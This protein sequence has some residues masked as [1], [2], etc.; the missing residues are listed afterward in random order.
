MTDKSAQSLIS[1]DSSGKLKIY[2]NSCYLYVN[3]S[4]PYVRIT[5]GDQI[6]QTSISEYP[7]G[8]W[9]EGFELK[10]SYHAQLFDTI[11]LDVYDYYLL[12]PDRHVGRA[13]IRLIQLENMPDTFTSFFEVWD[14]SLASGASSFATRKTTATSSV[15]ALQAKITYQFQSITHYSLDGK[16]QNR[17]QLPNAVLDTDS[18]DSPPAPGDTSEHGSTKAGNFRQQIQQYRDARIIQFRKYDE[19]DYF[20]TIIEDKEQQQQEHSLYRFDDR[21]DCFG[22]TEIS[23]NKRSF[24]G[25]HSESIDNHPLTFSVGGIESNIISH[26][27]PHA[28][29]HLPATTKPIQ[30]SQPEEKKSMM[31]SVSSWFAFWN[32][33]HPILSEPT[34]MDGNGTASHKVDILNDM[35]DSLKPYPILDAFGSWVIS[36]ETNQVLRAIRKLLAAFGQGFELSNLQVL[37]GSAVVEKFYQE[38]TRERTY[39][40]VKDVSEM[41][42]ASHL[43]RFSMA[44]YGWKGLNFI[45]QGNGY[46]LDA[47]RFHSNARSLMEHLS[48]SEHD[49]LAYEFRSGQAFRPSYFIAHDR[50]TNSIVLSIR[51][52]MGSFDTMTDLVCEY[53]PWK[54]G[55]VHKGMKNSA[56]WFFDHLAPKLIAYINSQPISALYIVGHSLGAATAAILTIMLLDYMDELKKGK[57]DNFVLQ[58][59]GYA[60]ACGLSLELSEKYK[61]HIQSV[62]FADDVVSKLCYGSMM[63]L[64]QMIIAGYEATQRTGISA[65]V[66][67]DN[68][69]GKQKWEEVFKQVAECR[70]RCIESQENPRLYVAGTVYQFW[71]DPT[72]ENKTRIV[73]ERTSAKRVSSELILKKSIILDHLPSTFDI[74]MASVTP[75][76]ESIKTAVEQD[77]NEDVNKRN[78]EHESTADKAKTILAEHEL[79][80]TSSRSGGESQMI[81]EEY[82]R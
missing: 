42:L 71:L 49:L 33:L 76:T 81:D 38:L 78:Q 68:G 41:Q 9:N 10:V 26:I 12:L 30:P 35:D 34:T 45:G 17:G 74:A 73:V 27:E 3:I 25:H 14:K 20:G 37:I 8:K 16:L 69:P 47:T 62:V 70:Q 43:W 65:L 28:N 54:G 64:K 61:D 1:T 50:S 32:P 52:T 75:T 36:K 80:H 11:Q 48:L 5:M 57:P 31:E 13:E 59:I 39:D 6:Y 15:G 79:K 56:M 29:D 40:I 44:S 4:R 18:D 67:S 53:E 46:F 21:Y 19:G 51:G 22:S 7:D 77:R 2:L 60:P 23:N 66:W 58:S 82:T 72:P 63:D 55:L 24:D